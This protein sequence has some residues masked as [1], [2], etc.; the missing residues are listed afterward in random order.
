MVRP[1]E[2]P[3]QLDVL[4]IGAG[5][6]GLYAL[7]KAREAGICVQV[8][9]RANAVGGTWLYN[10]YPGAR[11][12]IESVEYSYSFSDEIQQ[13]WNWTE[14]LAGQAEIKQ[15]L[16]F[17]A[18]RLD[19]R[20]DIRFGTTVDALTFD[21]GRALWT[22]VTESGERYEAPFVVA[23]TGILSDPLA[24]DIPGVASFAGTTMFTSRYPHEGHDF[25]GQRVALIGT[26]STGIQAAPM[27][28]ASAEHLYVVQ[29]SAAYT[30]RSNAR[31]FGPG[32][33]DE[34]KADYAQIRAKQLTAHVGAAR[35]S[36][37]SAITE[38]G[39]HPP[40]RSATREEKLQAIEDNGLAGALF[41]NDIFNQDNVTLVDLKKTP[42]TEVTPTGLTTSAGEL[43]VDVIVYATGFDALTGALNRIDVR[44]RDDAL[45]RDVW[46]EQG[47][48]SYLGLQIAGFP[49]LFMVGG[50]QSPSPG[51]N[52]VALMEQQ[53]DWI[54]GCYTF[55]RSGGHRSI[56]AQPTA[57]EEWVEA[58][59]SLVQGTV[60]LHPSCNSWWNGGNVPGKKRMYM[61]YTLGMP[62]YRKVCSRAAAD[63]YTGFTVAWHARIS[64]QRRPSEEPLCRSSTSMMSACSTPT[65]SPPPVP[66]Q[67]LTVPRCCWCTAIPATRT[68]GAGRF[69]TSGNGTGSSRSTCVG[70]AGRAHRRTA[71]SR[72]DSR[73]IWPGCWIS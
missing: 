26:G 66:L 27:I 6:S 32:E 40:I 35:L 57:Q 53:I 4:I 17:V 56:E 11:C 20:R 67:V 64:D 72:N 12:D 1:G 2:A 50:P 15:Y 37:F 55:L 10:R 3:R 18:D 28:A 51:S 31:P 14:T 45:L 13:E 36:A 73:R 41:W 24:P 48:V 54:T 9:E 68:T 63:G 59:S 29:R 42:L 21:D 60:I 25:T 16:N 58:N 61:A 30:L 34:L 38:S 65:A 8:L 44:G 39:S 33:F 71:M 49:N 47:P 22:A 43:D 52:Y 70:T 69:R 62:E 5:F 19:L 46:K 7:H 23:A